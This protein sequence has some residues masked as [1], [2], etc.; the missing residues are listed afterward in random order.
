VRKAEAGQREKRTRILLAI[1]ASKF[2]EAAIQA[3]IDRI[4]SPNAEVHVFTV[5][6][7]MDHFADEK[8]TEAA[9]APLYEMKLSRL[10]DA[11]ELVEKAAQLL[12]R[13]GFKANVGVAEGNPTTRII[14]EAE[15]WQADLIVLGSHGRKAFDRAL[16]GSVTEGVARYAPCSVEIVRTP[17]GR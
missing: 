17:D 8:K 1:D 6:D 15:Q 3:V 5:V 12:R 14:E 11:S 7:L 9:A 13:A 10:H 2:S 4:K 16:M